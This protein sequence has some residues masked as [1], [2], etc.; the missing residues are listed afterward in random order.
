[1]HLALKFIIIIL[2]LIVVTAVII[3]LMAVW[4]GQASDMVTG[5]VEFF[6]GANPSNWGIS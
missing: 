4:T 3:G 1:M 2:L 6:R 5:I